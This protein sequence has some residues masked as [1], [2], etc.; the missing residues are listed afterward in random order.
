MEDELSPAEKERSEK[1]KEYALTL[2][3]LGLGDLSSEEDEATGEEPN[4]IT[5]KQQLTTHQL[6]VFQSEFDR[7]KKLPGLHMPSGF[8]SS[9]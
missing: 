4:L 6:Q 9:E 3:S 5:L 8:S 2:K 1:E 7:R